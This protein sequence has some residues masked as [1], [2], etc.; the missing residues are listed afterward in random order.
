MIG[1]QT[2]T[3]FAGSS[4]ARTPTSAP[5]PCYFQSAA[6]MTTLT[7]TTVTM[8]SHDAIHPRA[9]EL[10]C[11]QARTAEKEEKMARLKAA[12]DE[13]ENLAINVNDAFG[14]RGKGTVPRC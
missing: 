5:F 8:Q 14:S 12:Y 11:L 6:P 4:H 2:H 10:K 1:V 7:P 3:L 13:H 9:D